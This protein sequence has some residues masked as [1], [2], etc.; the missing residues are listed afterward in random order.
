MRGF[1]NL[2]V[3][4]IWNTVAALLS[5]QL[6]SQQS[7]ALNFSRQVAG[8]PVHKVSLR[9]NDPDSPYAL[10]ASFPAQIRSNFLATQVWPSAR[11]AAQAV[12][13]YLDIP[14]CQSLIEF[15]CGPGL[16]SL[17]AA[18]LGVAIVRATDIDDFALKLVNQAAQEQNISDRIKTSQF[19]L[20]R[21][22]LQ[23]NLPHADIYLLSDVFESGD[24]AR[25]AARVCSEALL[26]PE[27]RLWVFA[28]SDRA[29]REVFLEELK[30]LLPKKTASVA[31]L[32]WRPFAQGPETASNIW[33]CDIDETSV[34]YS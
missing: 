19:D 29:Q 30:A 24:V 5:L 13:K 15:G 33:L 16:P 26:Q 12:I 21:G 31:T 20:V 22:S 27:S 32:R 6:A 7:A 3:P 25:G 10:A 17:T 2:L 18:K 11:T 9:R 23:Y 8:V 1:D 28:Q 34:V 4:R 14:K